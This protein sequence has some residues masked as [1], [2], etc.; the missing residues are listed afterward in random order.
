M[1]AFLVLLLSAVPAAAQSF[2]AAPVPVRGAPTGIPG[3]AFAAA[4]LT[5]K[6]S[7][8]LALPTATPGF[9]PT[10]TPSLALPS[11]VL[12][13]AVPAAV[14][15]APAVAA[16]KPA[17]L[18]RFSGAAAQTLSENVAELA[19]A[20]GPSAS[21]AAAGV[22]LDKMFSGAK[23][24]A[25]PASPERRVVNDEGIE[26]FGRPPAYYLEARRLVDKYKDKIDLSESLDVMDDAYADAWTKLAAIEGLAARRQIADHNT[27]LEDTLMWVDGV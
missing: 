7:L 19:Q 10:L 23:A 11:P 25:N 18:G 3:A 6:L 14:A 17:E 21:P 2:R 16:A 4:A 22:S 12:P 5:P 27:R 13:A 1:R 26:L 24:A 15:A 20:Q 9:A 8:P